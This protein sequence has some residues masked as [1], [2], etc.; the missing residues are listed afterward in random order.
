MPAMRHLSPAITAT[1]TRIRA[2]YDYDAVCVRSRPMDRHGYFSLALNGSYID[3]ML[4][5]T[6]RIFLE[7]NDRQPRGLCG[8]LIHISQV[9]A[10]VEYN[11]RSWPV[12][13]PV[14]STR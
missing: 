14:Q 11:H 5:K 2:E 12:L 13:P 7:V 9:D 3:A 6:K 8:S 4:D 1:S 10:I